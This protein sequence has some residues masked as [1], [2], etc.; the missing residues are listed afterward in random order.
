MSAPAKFD[1][2]MS[3]ENCEKYVS[4]SDTEINFLSMSIM[5]DALTPPNGGK[6]ELMH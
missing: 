4:R 6:R 2:S 5:S 3:I 1:G